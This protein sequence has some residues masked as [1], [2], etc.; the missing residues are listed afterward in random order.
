[1]VI[2]RCFDEVAWNGHGFPCC[3]Q[4]LTKLRSVSGCGNGREVTTLSDLQR[5]FLLSEDCWAVRSQPA[6]LSWGR[7]LW[8]LGAVSAPRSRSG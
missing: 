7:G 8:R 6:L 2:T 5:S 3:S 4:V 1:M